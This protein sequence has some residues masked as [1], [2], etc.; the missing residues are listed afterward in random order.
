[1]ADALVFGAP[2]GLANRLADAL[3]DV[4]QVRERYQQTFDQLGEPGVAIVTTQGGLSSDAPVLAFADGARKERKVDDPERRAWLATL[5]EG[6]VRGSGAFVV[7]ASDQA[8]RIKSRLKVDGVTAARPLQRVLVI[9]QTADQTFSE[10]VAEAL[11]LPRMAV[12]EAPLDGEPNPWTAEVADGDKWLVETIYFP[13]T[14]SL[15]DRAD[16]VVSF[17]LAVAAATEDPPA[18][19]ERLLFGVLRKTLKPLTTPQLERELS[20]VAHLTPVLTLRNEAE[21]D[22]VVDALLR[23]ATLPRR[24]E[25]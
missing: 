9:K 14:R 4:L 12:T 18:L 7:T 15:L 13:D 5:A 10:E 2:N 1:M 25:S 22:A 24:A 20:A 6:A 21:R 16:L 17:D 11:R 8:E 3:S 19:H 23:G